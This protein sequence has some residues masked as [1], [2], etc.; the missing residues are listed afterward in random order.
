VIQTSFLARIVPDEPLEDFVILWGDPRWNECI[1]E[2][3]TAKKIG[4]DTEFYGPWEADK[5][6]EIDYWTAT[7]R[8]LQ[9]GLPSGRVLFFDFGGAADN[10]DSRFEWYW[11]SLQVVKERFESWDCVVVGMALLTE[12]MMC[13][14]HLGWDMRRPVDI[15]LLSQLIWAGIASKPTR[16]TEDGRRLNQPMLKHNMRAIAARLGVEVSKEEQKSDWAGPLTNRQRNY[17]CRDTLVPLQLLPRLIYLIREGE[18]E[19]SAGAET[20][21]QVMFGECEFTGMPVH[22][23]RLRRTIDAWDECRE[24]ALAPFRKVFPG[25]DPA[26]NLESGNALQD[27]LD[28]RVCESCG[29][30]HDPI[31]QQPMGLPW[32]WLQKDWRC[33]GCRGPKEGFRRARVRSYVEE[34]RNKAGKNYWTT[35]TSA[36]DL[37]GVSDVWYVDAFLKWKSM[38]TCRNWLIGV[39]ENVRGGCIRGDYQQIAG[40]VTAKDDKSGRGMGR[41]S[42]GRPVNLQNPAAAAST[43]GEALGAPPI[44]DPIRPHTQQLVQ[45]LRELAAKTEDH[46]VR[47]HLEEEARI[48]EAYLGGRNEVL[49]IADLSQAHA[50]IAAQASQDPVMLRDFRAGADFHVAMARELAVQKGVVGQGG[51]LVS[52]AEAQAART[53]KKHPLAKIIGALRKTA[54]PVNYGS[55]NLQGP[56]TLKNTAETSPEPVK[57]SLEEATAARDVWRQLYSGLYRFQRS[58]IKRID[59]R[60]HT[61]HHLGCEGVYGES[62]ALTGR[63]LFLQKEYSQYGFSVKG[64]DAVSSIWMMTEADVMKHI[65]GILR[66]LFDRHPQWNARCRNMAHDELD[67]TCWE[68]Y[69]LVVAR[70]V[71]LTFR[72]G[73]RWGGV[74]DLPVEESGADHRDMIKESWAAK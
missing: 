27:A 36:D 49:I 73:M 66:R 48:I 14:I 46:R 12:Y 26:S 60:I 17:A 55:I 40:G 74:V 22:E 33:P 65:M 25:V 62:R 57:M 58:A 15:M 52:L 5:A 50:R 24:K 42:C 64:T 10:R 23:P 13:R 45:E 53:D 19:K 6:A 16:T 9:V 2:L 39:L 69:G 34:A 30:K 35:Y 47:Q 29:W 21:A 1:Q 61:F 31:L 67:I 4:V 32:S 68:E 63:R 56:Q 38:T 59:G 54:K 3:R 18:I 44:R 28:V 70:A 20:S 37:A 72:L 41:S 43:R 11:E 8:S 51:L 71:K 7:M